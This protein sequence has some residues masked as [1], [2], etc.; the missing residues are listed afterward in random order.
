[1]QTS[2]V[3]TSS[4][5]AYLVRTR[6]LRSGVPLRSVRPAAFWDKKSPVVEAEE[7]EEEPAPTPKRKENIFSSTISTLEGA[8]PRSKK[9]RD[10]LYEAKYGERVDG[11]MTREQY[12]ALRRKIGGTAKDYFKEW[13][14]EDVVTDTYTKVGAEGG[15]VPFLPILLGIVAAVLV[16]TVVV[17]GQTSQ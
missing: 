5:P 1:M 3:S 12:G 2:V 6:S 8:V 4:R 15:T 11:K 16:T 17:V 9:D 7:E 14:E 13:V 10:L